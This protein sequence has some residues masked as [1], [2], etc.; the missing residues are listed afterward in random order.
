M[1]SAAPPLD[2]FYKLTRDRLE[3]ALDGERMTSVD[4]VVA[5]AR[6]V[7]D[8]H[9]IDAERNPKRL[10]ASVYRL[11]QQLVLAADATPPDDVAALARLSAASTLLH[12][13]LQ[14]IGA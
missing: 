11:A 2:Q 9:S 13:L 6:V 5:W 14:R 3:V 10:A 1:A 4:D 8:L 7:V 12:E